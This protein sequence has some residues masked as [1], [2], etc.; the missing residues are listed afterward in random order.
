MIVNIHADLDHLTQ[1]PQ[2]GISQ[3]IGRVPNY[4]RTNYQGSEVCHK[5]SRCWGR[6][7]TAHHADSRNRGGPREITKRDQPRRGRRRTT[8]RD[9]V[10]RGRGPAGLPVGSALCRESS[11]SDQTTV[12][13]SPPPMRAAS[14]AE[15]SPSASPRALVIWARTWSSYVARS[16]CRKIPMGDWWR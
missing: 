12:Q 11:A 14:L 8:A 7:H 1:L 6:L 9:P 5:P 2:L 15:G 16:T 4:W 3:W 13:V 10:A